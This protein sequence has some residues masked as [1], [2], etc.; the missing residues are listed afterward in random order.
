M[1]A[2]SL[3]LMRTFLLEN[4]VRYNDS[5]SDM[6]VRRNSGETF[7]FSEHLSALIYAMLTNQTKWS[8]IV[9][10]LPEIDELFFF[11]D[12]K[13]IKQR[14]GTYFSDGIFKLKCGNISTAA[15]M[16]NL[17]HNIMV[18]EKIA[19][20]YGSVD[21]FITSEPAHRIVRKLSSYRSP[22]KI[23]MLGEALA[24]EYIRNV[25]IDACK[26][27]THLRRF[28]GGARMG[29]SHA[30]VASVDEVVAQV[31]LIAKENDVPQSVIDNLIW[32]YCADGYGQICTATPKCGMCVISSF[33]KYPCTTQGESK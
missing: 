28:L 21:A 17:S 33:C 2:E 1:N 29:H 10:H 4:G 27:D 12:K 6:V 8:R 5:I 20:D 3:T 24:W 14:P 18:M 13:E 7:S 26:P 9:P 19:D 11:Y 22:Y 31:E 30:P 15:Q 32:S 25:G 23:K 16:N